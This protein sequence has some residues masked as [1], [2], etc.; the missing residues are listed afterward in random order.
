MPEPGKPKGISDK[1]WSSIKQRVQREESGGP[2]ETAQGLE[3]SDEDIAPD[4]WKKIRE[5]VRKLLGPE[6]ARPQPRLQ[7]E[8]PLDAETLKYRIRMAAKL[9][10]L[11]LVKYNGQLRHVEVY[12]YRLKREKPPGKGPLSFY[13]TYRPPKEYLYAYCLL[14]SQI[15]AF[16]PDKIEAFYLT[17]KKF[18]KRWEI[19]IV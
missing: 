10:V 12:S 14:H 7:D 19:E 3:P 8:G 2:V 4:L 9:Q 16:N 18:S 13:D 1:L 5:R 6:E 17:D 11:A 15:H